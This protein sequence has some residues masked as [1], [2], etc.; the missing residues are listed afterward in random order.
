MMRKSHFLLC[1]L[2]LLAAGLVG[3]FAWLVSTAGGARFLLGAVSQ[4]TSGAVQAERVTGSLAGTLTLEKM[5]LKGTQWE[6]V[7]DKT[8]VSWRPFYMLSGSVAVKELRLSRV[9]IHDYMPETQ[10]PFDLTWPRVP[11]VLKWLKGWIGTFH[12]DDVVYQWNEEEPLRAE[13]LAAGVVW[14]ART[15]ALVNIKAQ[16][17]S[18]RLEGRLE[19]RLSRPSLKARIHVTPRNALADLE[20]IVLSVDLEAGQRPEQVAGPVAITGTTGKKETVA[21]EGRM[22]ITRDSVQL[23]DLTFTDTRRQGRAVLTG[24]INLA[25]TEP[26]ADLK[27][28]I[29]DFGILPDSKPGQ[30]LTGSFAV[31]GGRNKYQGRFDMEN[32]QGSWMKITAGGDF[33]GNGEAVTVTDL[34]GRALGGTLKGTVKVS[35]KDALAISGTLQGRNLDPGQILPQ[36]QGNVN[37]NASGSFSRPRE[38]EQEATV[39]AD[40]LESTIRKRP[41]KGKVD[42]SWRDKTVQVAS[43]SLK[44]DGFE[45][46]AG[47][48]LRE[49]LDYHL[50]AGDLSRLSPGWKGRLAAQGWLS[51]WKGR[52]AGALKGS[53]ASLSAGGVAAGV[54]DVKARLNEGDRDGVWLKARAEKVAVRGVKVSSA[55][56]DVDGRVSEHTLRVTA[57]LPEQKIRVAATGG[58]ADGIWTGTI[59]ELSG[60]GTEAGELRLLRPALFKISGQTLA[61]GPL[62]VAGKPGEE[63]EVA[64]DLDFGLTRGYARARW[65]EVNLARVKPLLSEPAMGGLSSGSMDLQ[66]LS[67]DRMTMTG[68]VTAAGVI[69]HG[70]ARFRIPSLSGR[71]TWDEKGIQARSEVAIENGGSLK[72]VVTSA[73]PARFGLPDTGNLRCTWQDIDVALVKPLMPR[74]LRING[75]VTGKLEGA[76][77]PDARFRAS[78]DSRLTAGQ[79]SWRSDEGLITVM[80]DRADVKY[81]WKGGTLQGDLSFTFPDY[82]R[83]KGKFQ[84]PLPAGF[85]LR[86]DDNG[87]LA[88]ET[89]GELREKGLLSAL[90]PG[91]LGETRGYIDFRLTAGGTWRN[92]DYGGRIHLKRAGAFLP[93][94]GIRIEDVT[95]EATLSQDL[96]TIT[97]LRARSGPGTLQGAAAVKLKDWR[98][99]TFKGRLAGER[100]QLI[101][102]PDLQ[103][104]VSPE[105]DFEGDTKRVALKGSV[106][107]PEA[108]IRQS[109]AKGVVRRSGDVVILDAPKKAKQPLNIALDARVMVV[110]GNKIFIQAEGVNARL[111]GKVLLTGQDPDRIIGDGQIHIVDGRYN[112]YG[113]KLDISRGTVAFKGVPVELASLDIMA[114][115]TINPGRFD[116]VKA[117]V[118]ITGTP[119]SPLIKLYSEPAMSDSDIFAYM[120]LGRPLVTGAETDQNMALLRTA[121][122]M[123]AGSQTAG[124]QSQIMT[125]LGIDTLDVETK[126]AGT[127]TGLTKTIQ[128][129]RTGTASGD[130][131]TSLVTIGKYLAPGLYISYGRSLFTDEY[132]MTARFTVSKNVEI[133]SKVGIQSGI[134]LYYKIEFN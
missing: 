81:D 70:T 108:H 21:L 94:A 67:R 19:T 15:L 41:V 4:M 8:L 51:W 46:S 113:V 127:A 90:F 72:A 34:V 71:F 92:P 98:V 99:G 134:D 76:F 28:R 55:E 22:G 86:I 126:T 119:K 103:V 54:V 48:T 27:L 36:I 122:T 47:G 11:T 12:A 69:S 17:P 89:Q 117:G 78:G 62:A 97:S 45:F 16:S 120:V 29:I 52:L 123:L 3:T 24:S 49:K 84:I 96:I 64:A 121:S 79:I 129:S 110:L 2:G 118:A 116:E 7:I 32:R 133:E 132:L 106:T 88:V 109:E 77:L 82:G 42:A 9:V 23:H 74:G 73:T 35:W 131:A 130:V 53:A 65:R 33:A 5:H 38:G 39:K 87:V 105:L 10:G 25:L 26:A 91:L 63:I 93:T 56:V 104:L 61:V 112:R 66:W 60:S 95:A 101:Y 107:V 85:P 37:V 20:G 128:S 13:S 6:V 14:Q 43:L 80:P 1:F 124:L 30:G 58:Y 44:G 59:T 125:K 100:F 40:L 50:R 115:R 31:K 114:T 68:A 57:S 111:E 83:V 18:A 102:L 75:R